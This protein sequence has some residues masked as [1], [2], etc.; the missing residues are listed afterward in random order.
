MTKKHDLSFPSPLRTVEGIT[1]YKLE[2]GLSVL[3]F[4]DT[5]AQ[6][7]TVNLT[8][9][10]GSRHEGRGEAGMAHLLEHMLFKG[11]PTHPNVKAVLQD[12]GALFNATTSFDRTNYFEI[13]SATDENLEFALKLEADRMVNSWIRQEDLDAEMT[14]VRNEFEMGENNPLHVLHDQMFSA[15]YRWHN[16]GKTTIGNRSDIERV[17]VKNLAAFYEHYYQPDNAVLVVAGKYNVA[18]TQEWILRYFGTLP[19]PSRVLDGTYTEEPTQDGSREVKLLRAGDVAQTA[20]AYHIPAASHPD[21]TALMVLSEVLGDEPSGLLYEA[22]VQ[23][24]LASELFTIPYALKEPGLFMAFARP[25]HSEQAAEVLGKMLEKLENLNETEVTPD[26]VERAKTRILKNY[27][28]SMKNSKDIALMLSES[29]SQGDYRL[30]FYMRDHVKTI[31][32]DDV[33]RV[34]TTYFVESNRTTGLFIPTEEPKRA[35][36]P[37]TPD[38]ECMLDG[39]C[40]SEEI[41]LGEVFEATTENID[42]HTSRSVLAGTIKTALLSKSTRGKANRARLLFRFGSEETL[43]GKSSALHLL[44]NLLRRG[45]ETKTFQQ[46][47]DALDKLQSSLE[48][49]P[50][51]N[52]VVVVDINSDRHHLEEVFAIAGDLMRAPRFSQDEFAVVQK[53]ELANLKEART[54]PMQVGMRELHRLT[55]PFPVDSIHYVP[56]VDEKI[57]AL[58]AV[59]LEDVKQLYAELYGA[60]HLELAIVGDFDPV[61]VSRVEACFDNWVSPVAYN[62]IKIPCVPA[63]DELRILRT[64]DKQMAIVAMGANFAMRDDDLNYPAMHMANYIFGESM[65]SRLMHRLRER[66]GLSYGA[67]SS[68]EVGRH[69]ASASLTFYAMCATDKAKSALKALQEEYQLWL[70]KG[71]TEQELAEGIQSFEQYF[72]NLLANDGFVLR[73]LGSMI[74]VNRNFGF[75]AQMLSQTAQLT[76]HDI[77]R[78]LETHLKGAPVATVKAGDFRE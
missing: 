49:Y 62:R 56:T 55:N 42:A 13:L 50:A 15:A 22:L 58:K 11:T 23:T 70:E 36:I 14:V 27:Q 61:A 75:Y 51:Q 66:E 59:T 57:A 2:N 25:A 26:R 24:G 28:L 72:N 65:K 18:K 34:A 52:G 71:V 1:E 54:D 39:Y 17:P 60:N 43:L 68:L 64:P 40:G 9:L 31:A 63:L 3:L 46:V 5:A 53:R 67:G 41:H 4:P 76:T 44:P 29:I 32:V 73:T 8:Y 69:D 6:N 21:Y 37:P 45:T 16:Y 74:D 47:E 35:N 7:V 20:V 33:L 78:A 38:V 10:V 77:Q 30:F 48:I 19:K 12:R